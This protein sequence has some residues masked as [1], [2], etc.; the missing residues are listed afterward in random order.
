MEFKFF[1]ED[2]DEL[3]AM[4]VMIRSKDGTIEIHR[5]YDSNEPQ[6]SVVDGGEHY[7]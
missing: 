1:I 5:I 3:D 6:L 4:D 7:Q 2:I